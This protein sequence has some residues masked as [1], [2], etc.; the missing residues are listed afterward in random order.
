MKRLTLA[1]AILI[2]LVLTATPALTGV[3]PSPWTPEINQLYAIDNQL[4]III[5]RVIISPATM[6]ISRPLKTSINHRHGKK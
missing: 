5:E 3:D 6:Q 2:A 1:L 4:Q